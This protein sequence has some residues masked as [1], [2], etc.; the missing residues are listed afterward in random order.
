MGNP[1]EVFRGVR[2]KAESFLTFW[3]IYAG[4]NRENP[5]F[6]NAYQRSLLFL[7]YIQGDDV[8]EW[9][10]SMSHWLQRQVDQEGIP[11]NDIWLYNSTITSFRRQYADI[12][13][14]EK[15]RAN[16]MKGLKMNPEDPD[17]YIA[18]FEEMVRH[19]GY[20]INDPLTIGHYT[21]GLPTGL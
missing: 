13:Q 5:A 6:A 2:A 20:N 15:A 10:Q 1:P 12:L 4:I 8:A 7:T 11:S 19:A 18:K 16:I 21:K 14:E 9:V 3:G 17:G